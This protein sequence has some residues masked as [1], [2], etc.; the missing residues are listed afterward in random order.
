MSAI[1][2]EINYFWKLGFNEE[3]TDVYVKRYPLDNRVS[4]DV[5]N[6]ELLEEKNE[7]AVPR[8]DDSAFAE[9]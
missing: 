6:E 1:L 7:R 2:N 8:G 3:T 4:I 9:A 5:E